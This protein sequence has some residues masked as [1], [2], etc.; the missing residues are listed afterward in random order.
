MTDL[1]QKQLFSWM[2]NLSSMDDYQTLTHEFIRLMD[3]I[4]WVSDTA[5]YEIYDH[6]KKIK[7]ESEAVK[8][9]LIRKFPLDLTR[10]DESDNTF[11]GIDYTSDFNLSFPNDDG[12]YAWVVF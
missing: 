10:K 5:V 7:G 11:I 12:T 8:E 3:E 2:E 9:V 4:S 6:D 1:P